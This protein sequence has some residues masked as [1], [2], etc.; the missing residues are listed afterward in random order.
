MKPGRLKTKVTAREVEHRYLDALATLRRGDLNGAKLQLLDVCST[1]CRLNEVHPLNLLIYMDSLAATLVRLG[2]RENA[3]TVLLTVLSARESSLCQEDPSPTLSTASVLVTGYLNDEKWVE[4][5]PLQRGIVSVLRK[6]QRDGK[7]DTLLA[8]SLLAVMLVETGNLNEARVLLQT[9]VTAFVLTLGREHPETLRMFLLLGLVLERQGDPVGAR[10]VINRSFAR[11]LEHL[12]EGHEITVR[13][14]TKLAALLLLSK[15]NHAA[16]AMLIQ[17]LPVSE[18]TTGPESSITLTNLNNLAIAIWNQG[19][20]ELARSVAEELVRRKISAHGEAHPET[21]RAIQQLSQ[22]ELKLS[23]RNAGT[24]T[25]DEIEWEQRGEVGDLPFLIRLR[26]V[27]K[28][29]WRQ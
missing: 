10:A 8:S 23:D 20:R 25:S 29:Q 26:G 22:M 11:A 19:K 18:R 2:D 5:L 6:G 21:K 13:L 27:Q 1:G 12:G 24:E 3:K 4:A 15:Q 14:G 9:L 16:S 17:I 28:R 7:V